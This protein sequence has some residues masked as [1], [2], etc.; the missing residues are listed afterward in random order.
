[1]KSIRKYS[2]RVIVATLL[3]TG[4]SFASF[5]LLESFADVR[6]AGV[7]PAVVL[8][9]LVLSQ[10]L[11]TCVLTYPTIRSRW[12][13]TQLIVGIFVVFF[14]LH[15]VVSLTQAVLVVPKMMPLARA[16]AIT[17]HGFLVAVLFSAVLVFV[18]GRMQQREFIAESPRL[19]LPAAEW[20]A[21]LAAC[22]VL[23]T[24][25]YLLGQGIVWP[26]L[27]AFYVPLGLAPLWQ[28]A[29]R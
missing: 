9:W 4:I 24:L 29:S 11:I 20:L 14:G 7:A 21:K 23:G 1:M 18:M 19:H 27:R 5:R 10:F 26:K 6:P 2:W 15:T 17:A 13:G 28:R 12:A 25:L 16:A 3:L 8:C 22:A